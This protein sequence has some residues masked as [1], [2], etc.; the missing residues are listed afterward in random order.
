[1]TLSRSPPS[2]YLLRSALD[3]SL[4]K[5]EVYA[6]PQAPDYAAQASKPHVGLAN[7]ADEDF[8][9]RIS[10]PRLPPFIKDRQ[11][12]WFVLIEAEF[13]VN[14]TRSDDAKS[15]ATIE[16][17]DKDVLQQ[18]TGVLFDPPMEDKPNLQKELRLHIFDRN[19]NQKY[20]IE[21]GSAISVAPAS[22]FSD[23]KR[24]T[25]LT[26]FAA[27]STQINTFGSVILNI[28]LNLRRNFSWNF[29]IADVQ[30]AITGADLLT[31]FNLLI[32]LKN[33]Q[34]ID[35]STGVTTKGQIINTTHHGISTIN[36]NMP[37]A[38]L[39][40]QFVHITK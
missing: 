12:L 26:L 2:Q 6:D 21:S 23:L 29:I 34:L 27:N 20:L 32:D 5:S 13:R 4:K 16:A 7:L 33:R 30:E 15:N 19:T 28:D 10:N 17:L 14:W 11:G 35:S 8:I 25:D 3:E 36:S 24:K 22:H 31:H 37:H 39:L 38:Y 18:S 9:T 40:L 1:M